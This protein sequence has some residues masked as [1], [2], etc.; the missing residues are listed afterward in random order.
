MRVLMTAALLAT[1]FAG[2]PAFATVFKCIASDG[3]VTYTN[4]PSAARNCERL[5]SDLPFSTIP[6]PSQRA[7]PPPPRPAASPAPSSSSSSSFPRVSP[8]TQR[9]RDDTRRQILERELD[10]ERS[11]LDAAQQQLS[12]EQTRDAPEDRIIEETDDGPQAVISEDRREARLQP[13][14]DQIELHQRNITALERELG[15]LR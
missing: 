5:R 14:H 11:A 3:G 12:A 13:L 15:R 10:G 9:S 1:A 8:E 2:A 7:A 4:D 6:A